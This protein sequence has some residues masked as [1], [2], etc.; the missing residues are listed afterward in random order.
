MKRLLGVMVV[1]TAP[2]PWARLEAAT[3]S[4]FDGETLQGW[5]GNTESWRNLTSWKPEENIVRWSWTRFASTRDKYER[6]TSDPL[7]A[8]LDVHRLRS[9][10]EVRAFLEA[11]GR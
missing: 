11:L 5:N 6:K 7:W 10:S 3:E 8:H 1:F 2:L 4:L 9:R